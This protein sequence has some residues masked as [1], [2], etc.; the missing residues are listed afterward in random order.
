[1]GAELRLRRPAPSAARGENGARSFERSWRWAA[2]ERQARDLPPLLPIAW[3][4][5][6]GARSAP[7]GRSRRAGGSVSGAK[8]P[9]V[10]SMGRAM[11]SL[12]IFGGFAAVVGATMYP[13]YFWPLQH[14]DE[15]KKEQVKNRAGIIQE[16]V[17]PPGLKVWSDPF[18]R[19]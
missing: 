1:E 12:L 3:K 17:Q 16:E 9:S 4:R 13:I 18:G 6:G 11:R 2:R 7:A 15:Y 10:R 5:K 8:A 19:K 14:L